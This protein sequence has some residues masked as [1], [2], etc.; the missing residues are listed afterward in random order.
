M[1]QY[2]HEKMQLYGRIDGLSAGKHGFHIHTFGD[3]SEGCTSTGGHYD[4][5]GVMDHA[6]HGST[7]LPAG[8]LQE[9]VANYQGRAV[10]EQTDMDL[11]LYGDDNI[12]GRAMVLHANPD[13]NAGPRIACCVIGLTAAPQKEQ[14]Y[15]GY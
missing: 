2:P 5:L 10:V 7:V 8:D 3:F 9:I 1:V 6:A 4:P 15:G 12:I 13:P 11:N 14:S